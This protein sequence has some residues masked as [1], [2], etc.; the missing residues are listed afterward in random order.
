M[1]FTEEILGYRAEINKARQIAFEKGFKKGFEE[2]LEL[3]RQEGAKQTKLI[4]AARLLEKGMTK[5]K[6]AQ[7]TKIDLV[8]ILELTKKQELLA[9]TKKL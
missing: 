5:Q 6:V 4:I 2:G 8:D 1:T 9:K 3:S 7:I